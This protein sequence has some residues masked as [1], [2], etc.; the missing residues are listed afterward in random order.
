MPTYLFEG[1]MLSSNLIE[2]YYALNFH[3]RG[4][5]LCRLPAG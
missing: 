4:L 2:F 1:N 3:T 5:L